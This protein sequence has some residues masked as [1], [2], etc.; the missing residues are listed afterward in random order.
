MAKSKSKKKPKGEAKAKNWENVN[1][2]ARDWRG[3][4]NKKFNST[5][6]IL[7]WRFSGHRKVDSMQ[8]HPAFGWELIPPKKERAAVPKTAPS[9]ITTRMPNRKRRYE[10]VRK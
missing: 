7:C 1:H 5:F 4:S 3:G 8:H 2:R 10:V 6:L 9:T